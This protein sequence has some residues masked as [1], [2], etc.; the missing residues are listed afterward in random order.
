M[1]VGR[2]AREN[3]YH[4]KDYKRGLGVLFQEVKQLH[5]RRDWIVWRLNVEVRRF[6]PHTGEWT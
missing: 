4:R 6:S 3:E 2:K 1:A 5:Q